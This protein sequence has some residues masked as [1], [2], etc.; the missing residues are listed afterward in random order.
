MKRWFLCLLGF[1]MIVWKQIIQKSF[2]KLKRKNT[3]KNAKNAKLLWNQYIIWMWGAWGVGRK[4]RLM[5]EKVVVWACG[6]VL[7]VLWPSFFSTILHPSANHGDDAGI[8]GFQ[9]GWNL[10]NNNIYQQAI[11]RL[12]FVKNTFINKQAMAANHLCPIF[13]T[14]STRSFLGMLNWALGFWKAHI[15]ER[16][17]HSL[18]L[19]LR[20]ALVEKKR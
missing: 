6:N 14:L 11:T 19:T 17:D 18:Q 20:E 3:K 1:N 9:Q 16:K 2:K 15:A 5:I 8:T 12:E 13:L 7:G 10:F 4:I